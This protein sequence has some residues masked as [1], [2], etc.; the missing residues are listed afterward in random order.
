MTGFLAGF[1][2]SLE[3][4]VLQNRREE[5][6]R[7]NQLSPNRPP[8]LLSPLAIVKTLRQESRLIH[9]DDS[10]PRARVWDRRRFS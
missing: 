10:R 6:D 5:S 7:P 8:H 1:I 3:K 2:L 9:T 4:V